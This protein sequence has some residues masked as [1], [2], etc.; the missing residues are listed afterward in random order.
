MR[1]DTVAAKR[2]VGIELNR[3]TPKAD[4]TPIQHSE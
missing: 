3:R 2:M 4:E 1:V